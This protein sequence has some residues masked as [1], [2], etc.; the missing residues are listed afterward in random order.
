M[1]ARMLLTLGLLLA[2]ATSAVAAEPPAAADL[3]VGERYEVRSGDVEPEQRFSGT[4][5]LRN[6]EWIV[7]EDIRPGRVERGVPLF[8]KVPVANRLFRSVGI[9]SAVVQYWIPAGKA[10]VIARLEPPTEPT[11]AKPQTLVP[12]IAAEAI[13]ATDGKLQNA[14]GKVAALDATQMTLECQT[15]LIEER[16]VPFLNEVPVVGK[17]FRSKTSRTEQATYEIPRADLICVITLDGFFE[18][19]AAEAKEHQAKR[20]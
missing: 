13:W 3:A 2:A 9:G 19:V 4:L 6:D 20:Q 1:Q 7:L 18:R 10:Q 11:D 5:I 8:P 15:H 17:W 14:Q 12:G 16:G